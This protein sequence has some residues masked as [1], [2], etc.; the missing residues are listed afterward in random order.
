MASIM[1]SSWVLKVP[2]SDEKQGY[3]L[4]QLSHKSTQADL[5]LTLFASEG[6]APYTTK[7]KSRCLVNYA[8]VEIKTV[9][10]HLVFLKL[11]RR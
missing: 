4:L 6:E 10:C 9:N 8:S 11:T 2:R 3:I 5:D 1:A 7:S